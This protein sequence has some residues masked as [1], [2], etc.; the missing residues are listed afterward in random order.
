MT[1]HTIRLTD[2]WQR[3]RAH[4][5]IDKAPAGYVVTVN[6]PKRTCAQSD[7]MWAM[8]TDISHAMPLGRRHTPDDWKAIVM[9][10]ATKQGRPHDPLLRRQHSQAIAAISRRA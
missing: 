4:R 2:D 1:G 5:L 8:L 10:G 6:E 9:N 3:A 7:K